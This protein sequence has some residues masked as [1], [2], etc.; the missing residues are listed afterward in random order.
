MLFTLPQVLHCFVC[1]QFIRTAVC[2]GFGLARY[3]HAQLVTALVR[4]GLA[5]HSEDRVCHRPNNWWTCCACARLTG[6]TCSFSS[7]QLFFFGASLS[8]RGF[9]PELNKSYCI[10]AYNCEYLPSPLGGLSD[11]TI[12]TLFFN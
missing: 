12:L 3:A 6:G 10:L 11:G 2:L 8:N 4:T 1:S 5:F 7:S 9:A